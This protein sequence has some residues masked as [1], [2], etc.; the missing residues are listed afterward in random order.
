MA[1]SDSGAML[2]LRVETNC[3]LIRPDPSPRR[4]QHQTTEYTEH[5]ENLPAD[6]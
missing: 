5:T 3:G 4:W 6:A 2:G 1:Y